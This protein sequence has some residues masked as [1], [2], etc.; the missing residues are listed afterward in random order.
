MHFNSTPVSE[1]L[2]QSSNSTDA[3]GEVLETLARGICGPA[4]IVVVSTTLAVFCFASWYRD[5]KCDETNRTINY[6]ILNC[7][8]IR[9]DKKDHYQFA[10]KWTGREEFV[11]SLLLVIEIGYFIWGIFDPEAFSQEA[12]SKVVVSNDDTKEGF[13]RKVAVGLR[14]IESQTVLLWTLHEQRGQPST[15]VLIRLV[16]MT[17]TLSTGFAFCILG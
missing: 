6:P 5:L 11:L 10:F 17:A 13:G 16:A 2:I 15:N 1:S 4:T 12:T 7:C 3:D 8:K 14:L 9:P